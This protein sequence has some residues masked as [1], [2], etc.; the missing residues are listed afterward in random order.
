MKDG[1][2]V[3]GGGGL[4]MQPTG[5]FCCCWLPLSLAGGRRKIMEEIEKERGCVYK[6]GSLDYY[7]IVMCF[8]KK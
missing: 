2:G 5:L 1:G 6:K 3:G 4:K 8:Q 7:K